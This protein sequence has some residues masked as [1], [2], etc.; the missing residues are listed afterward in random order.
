MLSLD[1]AA[2]GVALA[3]PAP[4]VSSP[5]TTV[6]YNGSFWF[7]TRYALADSLEVSLAG[8]FEPPATL[9]QNDVTVTTDAAFAG[10]L[11]HTFTRFG[12]QAGLQLVFGMVVRFRLGL[13]LG[14]CQELYT[15]LRHYGGDATNGF[16]DYGLT[17]A[18]SSRPVL[19][20]SP[21]IGL[22]WQIGDT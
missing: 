13:E 14:W 10:T 11:K 8:Y 3:V 16:L 2:G 18:D 22:E 7:G 17:L 5:R 20:L 6:S 1:I 12:A 9:W 4:P 15:G 21:L 19:V